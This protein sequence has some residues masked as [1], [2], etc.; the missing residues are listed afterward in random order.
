MLLFLAVSSGAIGLSL[1]LVW[2]FV[3]DCVL[4]GQHLG[5]GC[6]DQRLGFHL[7]SEPSTSLH[8]YR[9]PQCGRNSMFLRFPHPSPSCPPVALPIC[10]PKFS[11]IKRFLLQKIS[12]FPPV[13]N[14]KIIIDN[15]MS[16]SPLKLMLELPQF[17]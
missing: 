11:I 17:S 7:P 15:E 12:F 16:S 3:F 14:V 5:I 4:G 2:P 10:L 8:T 6:I 13:K 9:G 1:S